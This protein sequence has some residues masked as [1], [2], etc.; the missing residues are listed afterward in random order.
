MRWFITLARIAVSARVRVLF[1]LLVIARAR[2]LFSLLVI[3]RARVLFSLFVIA[4]VP[5]TR[6]SINSY[7]QVCDSHTLKA[8][9]QIS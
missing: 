7:C 9:I 5:T 1:S 6:R 8:I 2:V 3:A 4:H